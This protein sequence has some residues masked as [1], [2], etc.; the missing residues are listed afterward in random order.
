LAREN[1]NFYVEAKRENTQ[2]HVRSNNFR[3]NANAILSALPPALTEWLDKND[4][5]IQVKFPSGL[6]HSLVTRICDE[7][8]AKVPHAPIRIVQSLTLPQGSEFVLLRRDSQQHFRMGFVGRVMLKAGVPVQLNDP[9]NTP[10]QIG[11]DWPP[12]LGAVRALIKKANRQLQNDAALSSGTTGFIVMQ[13]RGGEQL[14]MAIEQ[15]YLRNFPSCCLGVT[16]VPEIPFES[17]QIVCQDNLDAKT[18]EK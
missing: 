1:R 11:F 6:S 7:L 18:L 2:D 15:R 8:S 3:A 14:G 4:C 10:V 5:R 12:N 17:G 13:A 9:R 16:L